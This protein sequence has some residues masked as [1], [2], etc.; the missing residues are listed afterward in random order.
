MTTKLKFLSFAALAASLVGGSALRAEPV[1][2]RDVAYAGTADPKQT[3]DMYAPPAAKNAPVVIWIHGSGWAAGDKAD[4][5]VLKAKACT[6]KGFM[7]VSVNYRLLFRPQDHPGTARPAVG[8]SDI[9]HD[10]A[11]AIRWVRDHIAADGGKPDTLFIAGHSAGAQLAALI[12]TDESYLS[13]AGVPLT[14]IRG[15]VPIDG[16]SYLPALQIDTSYPRLADAY[17]VKFPDA[18]QRKL[19]SVLHVAAGKNIPPFLLI[20][21]TDFPETGTAVQAHILAQVLGK[22]HIPAT[23]VGAHGKTHLTLDADL[24]LAGDPA[25]TAMFEFFAEQIWL[26]GHPR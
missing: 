10:I 17:R 1:I 11:A 15:C 5:I 26:A 14:A 8:I 22:S 7:L 21:V 12:C 2:R 16:D 6:D 13:A 9:E 18:A 20:H 24:G 25:T 23:L 4:N 19:S 3:L